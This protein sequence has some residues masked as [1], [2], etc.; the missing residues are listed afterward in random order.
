VRCSNTYR[1]PRPAR[2]AGRPRPTWPAA[3]PAPKRNRKSVRQTKHIKINRNSIRIQTRAIRR[4]G[5]E[6]THFKDISLVIGKYKALLPKSWLDCRS[7]KKLIN[8]F[9]EPIFLSLTLQISFLDSQKS[10]KD[11]NISIPFC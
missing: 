6:F 1:S 4:I 2:R 10:F 8:K 7:I 11:R 9:K 5:I 3:P